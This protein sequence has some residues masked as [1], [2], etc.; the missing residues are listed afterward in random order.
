MKPHGADVM[1][2]Y[3]YTVELI[4]GGRTLRVAPAEP[5]F[6]PA[7]EWAKLQSLRR[8]RSC[9]LNLDEVR[10]AIEPHWDEALGPPFLQSVTAA[11]T[12][13]GASRPQ[14]YEI[15]L[16]VFAGCAR[17]A[18]SALVDDGT[19]KSGDPFQYRVRAQ[20]A[21]APGAGNGA[22]PRFSVE[23][24]PEALGLR[25][26]NIARYLV[27][28]AAF[29]E[30]T[31]EDI[32]VF[33]PATLLDEVCELMRS[34][35]AQETGGVLIGHL[36]RDVERE[37]LLLEV[38]AQIPVRHAE[39][40]LMR[41]TFTPESWAAADAAIAL[42]RRDEMYV[43][44]W[45]SH[46]VGAWCDACPPEVRAQCKQSGSLSGDF[47]SSHDVAFHRTAFTRAYNVALLV[48]EECREGASLPIWRLFGWRRGLVAA[49]GFFALRSNKR[50]ALARKERHGA[51]GN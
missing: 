12:P 34:A 31:E 27:R 26:R 48:C 21:D 49:R 42:R 39:Q 1:A 30:E 45:H 47:F 14:A 25:R 9:R 13:P 40:E 36:H 23:A 3:T 41:L 32:P 2:H 11:V 46:P 22:R 5:D 7:L 19:L 18:S 50:S 20:A 29:G 15:P 10:A 4:S 33:I 8:G 37:D 16:D 44:W 28:A 35:G 38:T 43:G 6:A 17:R 51:R 24:V